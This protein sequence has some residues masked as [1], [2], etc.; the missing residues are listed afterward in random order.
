[1]A[2]RLILQNAERSAKKMIR[3]RKA[4]AQTALSFFEDHG[5]QIN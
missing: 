1:M 3:K 4:I 2:Q 5:T